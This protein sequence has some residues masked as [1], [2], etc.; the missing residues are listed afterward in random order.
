MKRFIDIYKNLFKKKILKKNKKF[1]ET[2]NKIILLKENNKEKK[3]AQKIFDKLTNQIITKHKKRNYNDYLECLATKK[4]GLK[5]DEDVKQENSK[6]SEEDFQKISN[7]LNKEKKE[8]NKIL[9][10]FFST[11]YL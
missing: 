4:Y 5:F 11:K 6:I 9:T 8:K 3:E 7:T 2:K 1:E 10:N